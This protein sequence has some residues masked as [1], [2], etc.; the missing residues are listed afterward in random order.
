MLE[1]MNA[2][3]GAEWASV[4]VVVVYTK[5]F[6][7]LHRYIEFPAIYHKDPVRGHQQAARAGRDRR[8]R[9]RTRGM[10]EFAA[11]AGLA[12]LRP[13]GRARASTRS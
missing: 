10:R 3:D 11:H 6:R 2:K 13:V 9:R 4:P 12:V 7:E 8:S 5:D 1:F